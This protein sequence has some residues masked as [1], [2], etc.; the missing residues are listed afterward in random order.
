MEKELREKLF[1]DFD[2][3]YAERNLDMT[4]TAMKK[5]IKIKCWVAIDEE[6]NDF[7]VCGSRKLAR[8]QAE[9]MRGLDLNPKIRKAI[10]IV[11]DK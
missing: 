4:K 5:Q 10:L 11:L 6:T 9:D 1:L 8:K 3:M 2:Q 7:D